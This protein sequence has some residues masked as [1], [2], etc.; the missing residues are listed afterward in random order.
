M[1]PFVQ[2]YLPPA[3]VVGAATYLGWPPAKPLDLGEDVVRATAVRWR[4]KDLKPPAPIEAERNPFQAAPVA[5]TEPDVATS[6]EL[7]PEVPTGP[8]A[9]TIKAGLRLDGFANLGGQTWA[10]INGRPRLPGDTVVTDDTQQYQCQLVAVADDSITVRYEELIV[11]IR[12]GEVMPEA[13]QSPMKRPR[14]RASPASGRR[15]S[16]EPSADAA[17][18]DPTGATP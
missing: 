12:P 13:S 11:E 3:L 6:A 4:P 7:K 18:A 15:A 8:S 16:A 10:L 5:S 14:R 2:R 9:E 17:E 1:N